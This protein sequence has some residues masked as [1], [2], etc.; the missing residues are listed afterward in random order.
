MNKFLFEKSFD[1]N[2]K[3]SNP[4]EQ[5]FTATDVDIFKSIAF[6]EGYN[7]AQKANSKNLLD[8]AEQLP[9]Q[10]KVLQEQ[11]EEMD[12]KYRCIAHDIAL[13]AIKS[14]IPGAVDKFGFEDVKILIDKAFDKLSDAGSVNITVNPELQ[15]KV[16]EF[17][18]E[19]YKNEHYQI[20]T[21]QNF[22]MTDCRVETKSGSVERYFERVWDSIETLLLDYRPKD[23]ASYPIQQDQKG[24]E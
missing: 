9:E 24:A 5:T 10:F 1:K 15:S 6:E 7:E 19:A 3:K 11:I 18:K 21:D 8:V 22:S 20:T 17:I 13:A 16:E 2:K 23:K 12:R 14:V 4:P